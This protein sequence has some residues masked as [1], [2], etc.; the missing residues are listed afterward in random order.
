MPVDVLTNRYS[1][2]R[3]GVNDRETTLIKRLVEPAGFGKLFA[4]TVDGDLYAQPLI[5]SDLTIAGRKRDVVYL[6]TSRNW[7]YA[8]D[9][10]DPLEYRPLWT[11]QLG[12]AVPRDAIEKGYLNFGGEVGVTSTPAIDRGDA[13]GAIFVA[14]KT[15]EGDR[16]RPSFAYRL[17][18]LDILTGE[19]RAPAV[20]IEATLKDRPNVR[21]D[22]RLNLNRPGLLLQ[23]NV[24]YL[25]FGSHDDTG[26][27]FGWILAYDAATLAQIA[28][29]ATAPEWGE[30]GVWQ[31]GTGLAADADGCV[32]AVV[33]NGRS[34]KENLEKRR[35]P[36]K[37]PPRVEA[38]V[39][40]NA[41]LKLKLDRDAGVLRVADW[42]TASDVFDLNQVDNDFIGGPVLFQRPGRRGT[43][44]RYVLGGGKDGK[45][46]VA[47]RDNMGKW[48]PKGDT[49]ILQAD[50]FCTFHIH[51][52]PVVWRKSDR[53]IR[54]FVWSE[55]DALKAFRL[56][57]RR[58][59]TTPQSISE[60]RLPNNELRMPGG[61]LTL[62]WDGKR[63]NTAVLWAVHS[64]REDAMNKTV[65]GT[66]RAYDPLDLTNE[67]W[68]SDMDAAEADKLGN[69]AKFSPPVVANGKVYV[70][71]FSRE[72]VVYG[73]LGKGRRRYD[74]GIFE[75]RNI[76]ADV[77]KSG[78][79]AGGRYELRMTGAGIGTPNEG[80]LFANVDRDPK[81]GVITI[82]ARVDGMN[83]SMHPEARAGLMMRR[84]FDKDE[85][86]AALV[87]SKEGKA[88]FLC[89][90]QAP[91]ASPALPTRQIDAPSELT[92]PMAL[93]LTIKGADGLPGSVQVTAETAGSVAGP[94]RAV[95]EPTQ[96]RLDVDESIDL[97]VGLCATAQTVGPIAES[98][99]PAWV[100]FSKV[101]VA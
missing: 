53:D 31:S 17:H 85:G 64:T 91:A 16:D 101:V 1:P 72:L 21:F 76:S 30:G 29:Y 80:F 75:L 70:G 36:L 6:A 83:A 11:R 23:D 14:T 9:A 25:A 28:A 65:A 43:V 46:Y 89:R 8:Y 61:I 4:R 56:K 48:T 44:E 55:K 87:V 51:G 18:A 93:R 47:D 15:M 42:F 81:D 19:D 7:V 40:G 52:A 10:D 97:K 95:G 27:Y 45:F 71:T 68:N 67:L 84:G 34:P 79:R 88:T 96:L 59:E 74:L 100:R 69:L 86:F 50:Q 90:E 5:V 73:L 63:P 54:A 98:A 92:F 66:L 94:F 3:A 78:R 33:G 35:P 37:A 39:Y 77:I 62:S 22:P 58:F 82:V 49:S 26:D 20:L 24:V 2:S 13:G 12:Q 41:I 38:P 99:L 57:G 60:Y 32:Y